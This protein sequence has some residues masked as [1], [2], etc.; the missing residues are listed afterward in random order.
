MAQSIPIDAPLGIARTGQAIGCI[1]YQLDG[2]TLVSAFATTG[3]YEAPAGSGDFHHAGVSFPDA[4]GV[5]AMGISGTEYKRAAIE[6][7]AALSFW[8]VLTSAMTTS[9]SMGKWIV[10]HLDARVSSIK[11]GLAPPSPPK[12]R[13]DAQHSNMSS[14]F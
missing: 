7:S 1:V 10:D 13:K 5:V 11:R 2:S 12:K 3:W 6:A 8:D 14:G 4:G 9:G